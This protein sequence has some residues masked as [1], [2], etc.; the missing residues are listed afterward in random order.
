M[1]SKKI[2]CACFLLIAICATSQSDL[3][4]NKLVISGKTWVIMDT[5]VIHSIV[6]SLI[7][8]EEQR[9]FRELDGRYIEEL[10]RDLNTCEN[11]VKSKMR[12]IDG[13]RGLD[14]LQGKK[15]DVLNSNIS[16]LEKKIKK[17][18]FTSRLFGSLSLIGVGI[19]GY[20][21]GKQ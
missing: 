17:Q 8:L 9:Y 2:L 16:S 4:I 6:D 19:G 21:I 5:I 15:I 13:F 14:S 10:H 3:P 7:E 1:R 20:L 18:K 12:V 11:I